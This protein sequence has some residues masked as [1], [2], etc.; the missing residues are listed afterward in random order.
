[1]NEIIKNLWLSGWEGALNYELKEHFGIKAQLNLARELHINPESLEYLK[2][3]MI[4]HHPFV[5]EDIDKCINF[6]KSNIK[7]PVLV[8]CFW[9][10]SRSAGMILCYLLEEG[11][12]ILEATTLLKLKRPIVN[13]SPM[14]M[15]SVKHHYPQLT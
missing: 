15:T 5:K 11:W 12:S 1:M 2:L 13:I 10:V 7:S 6:I 3:D 14:I 4:D 8:N 9:G